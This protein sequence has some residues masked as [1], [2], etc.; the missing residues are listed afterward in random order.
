MW[1]RISKIA[2]T[3]SFSTQTEVEIFQKLIP[4]KP[5]TIIVENTE[6]SQNSSSYTI[7]RK[8]VR[9]SH[10]LFQKFG[11]FS[12]ATSIALYTKRKFLT[13][14]LS[15]QQLTAFTSIVK[16]ITVSVT[17]THL[18]SSNAQLCQLVPQ[19]HKLLKQIKPA[20]IANYS[21]NRYNGSF[22]SY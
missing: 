21:I 1:I 9:N 22:F 6:N 17:N 2:K 16:R 15:K 20:Y 8:S 19:T 10:L 3:I 5:S 11:S 7:D 13:R 18:S 12:S 14:K 4:A